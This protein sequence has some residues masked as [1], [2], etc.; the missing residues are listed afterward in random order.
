MFV[1]RFRRDGTLDPMFGDSGTVELD[2]SPGTL[3][4]APGGSYRTDQAY[5]LVVQRDDKIII[6]AARGPDLAARP[7]RVDRDFAII[8]LTKHGALDPSWGDGGIAFVNTRG[9][10]DASGTIE[11]LNESPR[12]AIVQPNGQV[13]VGSYSEGS[14]GRALMRVLRLHTNGTLDPRFGDGGI[15]TAPDFFGGAS[16]AEAYDVGLQGR[17]YVI[18]GYGA[19]TTGGKV[20]VISA[21]FTADGRWDRSY[22]VDGRVIVDVAGDNDRARDL[23]VLDDGR[24]LLAGSGIPTPPNLDAMLVMLTPD[25]APVDSF[26]AG[27]KLLVDFGG[28]ADSFF[29]LALTRNHNKAIASGYLGASTGGSTAVNVADDGRAVRLRG[30]SAHDRHDDHDDREDDDEDDEG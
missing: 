6:V 11:D 14:D 27:G 28:G 30:V 3:N 2:L 1:S 8:R 5:G 13:V 25:G 10:G 23:V 21:R 24:I 12:Q 9:P 16:V 7:G 18:A 26:G 4:T 29:G 19:P 22:G 17:K 15:A 20:D